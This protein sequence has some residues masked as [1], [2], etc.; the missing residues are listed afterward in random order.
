MIVIVDFDN[1]LNNL[2]EGVIELYNST[3][4]KKVQISDLTSYN[5][6][7]CLDQESADKIVKSF[8]NKS[9]WVGE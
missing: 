7:D 1:V 8:K 9:L 5:F 3:S 2:T 6:Y 4:E